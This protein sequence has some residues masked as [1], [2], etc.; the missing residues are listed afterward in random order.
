MPQPDFSCI[1]FAETSR[2]SCRRPRIPLKQ[3]FEYRYAIFHS[4]TDDFIRWTK[5]G[6]EPLFAVATGRTLCLEDD[7]GRCRA[8]GDDEAG[9]MSTVASRG[10]SLAAEANSGSR[11]PS[12]SGYHG[13][14]PTSPR[15]PASP[16]SGSC[17]NVRSKSM[18]LTQLCDVTSED[19]A[20]LVF[21]SLPVVVKRAEN[22]D[23]QVEK[24]S[25]GAGTALPLLKHF[26]QTGVN[27][28]PTGEAIDVSVKFIGHPGVCVRDDADR[29][30]LTDLLAKHSCIPVFLDEDVVQKHNFFAEDYLWPVFHNMKIFDATITG[31]HEYESFDKAL[32][33]S[34]LNLNNAYA[35]VITTHGL[36]ATAMQIWA[37]Q[38]RAS[39]VC[40]STTNC[41]AGKHFHILAER[42][43]TTLDLSASKA[44][45]W[46]LTSMHSLPSRANQRAVSCSSEVMRTRLFGSTTTSSSLRLHTR[47]QD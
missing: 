10:A 45:L 35:E 3:H 2:L 22:G 46:L 12:P 24:I 38:I 13:S 27:K 18:D 28:P 41:F 21:R 40:Y 7:N 20:F 26:T 32:W 37:R 47:L 25:H 36:L 14:Q 29:K 39:E 33:K 6:E 16:R 31:D 30:Q 15:S 5:E 8:T 42:Q 9:Q 11:P 44:C 4:E 34:F 17:W 43:E 1:I 19:S 23:W